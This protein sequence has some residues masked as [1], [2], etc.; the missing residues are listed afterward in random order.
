[1]KK[2]K[3]KINCIYIKGNME[4]RYKRNYFFGNV[5]NVYKGY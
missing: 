4:E 3:N 5:I 1:M 2:G